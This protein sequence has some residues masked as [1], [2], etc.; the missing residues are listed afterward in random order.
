MPPHPN[1][2]RHLLRRKQLPRRTSGSPG[3]RRPRGQAIVVGAVRI[4]EM[5]PTVQAMA[6][7]VVAGDAAGELRISP[8]AR[9]WGA[10]AA[11]PPAETPARPPRR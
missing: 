4:Q 2:T 7:V 9:S 8:Q 11:A 5:G 3:R 1:R 10:A 6:T